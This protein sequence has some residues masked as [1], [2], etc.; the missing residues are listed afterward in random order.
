MKNKL[1]FLIMAAV[2]LLTS[3]VGCRSG[4]GS[5]TL[6]CPDG[7]VIRNTDT[8]ESDE[9]KE[10]HDDSESETSDSQSSASEASASDTS[11]PEASR[12]ETTASASEA[13]SQAAASTATVEETSEEDAPAPGIHYFLDT[14]QSMYRSPEVITVHSAAEKAGAGMDKFHYILGEEGKLMETDE[15]LALSGQYGTGAV[16]DVIGTADIPVDPEGVNVLTTDLQSAS[17]TGTEIGRWLSDTGCSGFTF[18][19]FTMNYQGTVEFSTYTSAQALTYVSVSNC[20]FEREFLMIVFGENNLVKNFDET[21]QEKLNHS[22]AYD[23]CHVS[24]TDES[25][26]TTESLLTLT[27]SKYFTKNLA[28]ITYENNRYCYGLEPADTSGTDFTLSNT[29]VYRKSGKSA[30]DNTEAVRVVLYTT[31][32]SEVP[33]I[34]EQKVSVLEYDSE[35]ETFLPSG[36]SFTVTAE[37]L[38]DGLPASDDETLNTT[39]G[40][41]LIAGDE[42]AFVVTVENEKLPK[43]LYAVETELVCESDEP[44]S[45]QEFAAEHSAGLEEYTAALKTECEPVLVNGE[46]SASQYT[47]TA[48][49]SSVFSRLLNFEQIADELAAAGAEAEGGNDVILFRVMIDNR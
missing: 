21:F 26:E 20:S 3:L 25:E 17:T 8:D 30:N 32:D 48:S 16:I 13:S 7:W 47:R 44:V 34:A 35:T 45:L 37:G 1:L 40:G 38:L 42:P 12:E 36:T 4:T 15:Q 10:A 39:L 19:I 22:M 27:S 43:G 24:M 18:Y 28:G 5:G 29:F 46:P 31:P 2:L 41:N 14:S 33:A 11:D 6:P 49:G 9:S 23:F